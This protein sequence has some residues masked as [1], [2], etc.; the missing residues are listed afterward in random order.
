MGT[1]VSRRSSNPYPGAFM[2]C[3]FSLSLSSE[4]TLCG[5]GWDGE[6]EERCGRRPDVSARPPVK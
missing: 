2:M 4:E 6:E 5:E 3:L 1:R